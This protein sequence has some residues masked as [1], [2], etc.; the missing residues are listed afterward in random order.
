M[1]AEGHGVVLDVVEIEGPHTGANMSTYVMKS[2]KDFE[3]YAQIY[4]ITGG[5]ANHGDNF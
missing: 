4:W 1:E 3:I 5:N 2:L